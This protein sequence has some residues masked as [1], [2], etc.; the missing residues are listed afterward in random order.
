MEPRQWCFRIRFCENRREF[1]PPLL[2]HNSCDSNRNSRKISK[3][4]FT[5]FYINLSKNKLIVLTINSTF[6][7]STSFHN[8]FFSDLKKRQ[9]MGWSA[10]YGDLLWFQKIEAISVHFFL[11][12][13]VGKSISFIFCTH[14]GEKRK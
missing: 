12:F 8:L 6:D 2:Q 13:G 14:N 10:S 4:F 1:E 11:L 7:Y 5:F 9:V 3:F